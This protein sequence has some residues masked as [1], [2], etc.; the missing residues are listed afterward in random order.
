MITL[1]RPHKQPFTIRNY[2]YW[3]IQIGQRSILEHTRNP[4]IKT[5]YKYYKRSNSVVKMMPQTR[6]EAR[7]EN[8]EHNWYIKVYDNF[9]KCSYFSHTST[10]NISHLQ[11]L[12]NTQSTFY[13]HGSAEKFCNWKSVKF[14]L[15][16]RSWASILLVLKAQND[17]W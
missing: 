1:S 14:V 9:L 13:K 8:Q 17:M 6:K 5:F 11:V 2:K 4:S 7:R 16:T 3:N 12:F 10:Y 15:F